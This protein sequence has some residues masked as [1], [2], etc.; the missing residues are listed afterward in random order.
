[1][2]R[3]RT[4]LSRC[5][6]GLGGE[7]DADQSVLR[8]ELLHG[9]G[10]VVDEGEASR[11]ATTEL[12]AHAE[13]GDLVLL[14]LVHGR[15]LLTELLLGDVGAA[16]VQDVTV[17]GHARQPSLSFIEVV[18]PAQNCQCHGAITS[19][20]ASRPA[21]QGVSPWGFA[22]DPSKCRPSRPYRLP[23]KSAGRAD[24]LSPHVLRDRAASIRGG[25]V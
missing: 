16:G 3:G 9:L 21:R 14:G 1:M 18:I 4:L 19:P 20:L 24:R 6:L 15:E 10:R 17:R 13:D 2:S 11:L 7:A 5:A 25:G 12:G 23:Q 8:L 22:R